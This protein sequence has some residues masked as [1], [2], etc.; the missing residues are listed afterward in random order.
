MGYLSDNGASV[1]SAAS[2]GEVLDDPRLLGKM[3]SQDTGMMDVLGPM[4]K[5]DRMFARYLDTNL[6]ETFSSLGKTLDGALSQ[7]DEDVADKMFWTQVVPQMQKDPALGPQMETLG[8]W[9]NV[10][11]KVGSGYGKVKSGAGKVYRGTRGKVTDFYNKNKTKAS[12][13]VKNTMKKY[14]T[15]KADRRNKTSNKRAGTWEKTK[16]WFG[17]QGTKTKNAFG[18]VYAKSKNMFKKKKV[19]SRP[20]VTVH[21]YYSGPKIVEPKTTNEPTGFEEG[22]GRF[23]EQMEMFTP[24]TQNQVAASIPGMP[25][26]GMDNLKGLLPALPLKPPL[27]GMIVDKIAIFKGIPDISE[28]MKG[29]MF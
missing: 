28:L 19:V 23:P 10:K 24:E 17:R 21:Q 20:T 5:G 16:N 11:S 22:V 12:A 4:V 18:S 14:N 3:V 6:T 26:M 25:Q 13:G 1:V 29:G 15:W 7:R 9:S 27:P 2:I 8:F